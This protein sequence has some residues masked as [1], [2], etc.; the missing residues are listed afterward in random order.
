MSESPVRPRAAIEARA[1]NATLGPTTPRAVMAPA[2]RALRGVDLQLRG[3]AVRIMARHGNARSLSATGRLGDDGERRIGAHRALRTRARA[4]DEPLAETSRSARQRGREAAKA[5]EVAH[6][7]VAIAMYVRTVRAPVC[8]GTTMASGLGNE[9]AERRRPFGSA[10]EM[11]FS[12]ASSITSAPSTYCSGARSA[13]TRRMLFFV[14]RVVGV[15]RAP[16]A[17]LLA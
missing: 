2:I 7:A 3:Q 11:V 13:I 10:N 17:S 14:P 8:F 5:V 12:A 6:G 9:A 4:V 1:G 15:P 16:F